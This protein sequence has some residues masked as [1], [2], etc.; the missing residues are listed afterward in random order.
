MCWGEYEVPLKQP[1]I[2]SKTIKLWL[3]IKTDILVW[4]EYNWFCNNY[5]KTL[6]S[7]GCKIFA[8]HSKGETHIEVIWKQRAEENILTTERNNNRRM[9]KLT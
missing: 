4:H 8:S 6:V 1:I 3:E 5:N 7:Y 2:F 9:H